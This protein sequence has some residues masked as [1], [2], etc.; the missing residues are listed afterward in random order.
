MTPIDDKQTLT[1]LRALRR[2]YARNDAAFYLG[3]W[4]AENPHDNAESNAR[5][6]TVLTDL[7]RDLTE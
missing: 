4:G 2:K 3:R 7:I 5:R 1:A 6:R